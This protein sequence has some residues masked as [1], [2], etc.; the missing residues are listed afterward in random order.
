[1][2]HSAFGRLPGGGGEAEPRGDLDLRQKTD[3]RAGALRPPSTSASPGSS[4]RM[5]PGP[6]GRDPRC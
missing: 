2:G 6:T 1:L 3:G 5:L 4:W